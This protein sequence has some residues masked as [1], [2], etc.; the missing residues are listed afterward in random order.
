MTTRTK[1]PR[2]YHLP[3][4]PGAT[5]DDKRLGDTSLFEGREVVVTE[6]LDGECTTLY[7]DGL[8]ARSVDGARHAWQGP[9]RALH[10]GIAHL[11]P[12][13]WR[14]CGENVY[15]KHS[16]PY[17]QLPGPFFVFG[18]YDRETCL[19]W[20]DTEAMAAGLGL[21]VAPVL[22]RGRWDALAAE[23][24]FSGDG[25]YG[26]QEGFVVRV[27]DAFPSQDHPL[28]KWVRAGH[29][30]TGEHWRNRWTP[31]HFA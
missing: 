14:V 11:I 1:Y 3:T 24:C 26:P 4:S 17:E 5:S 18:I 12:S 31:N 15:A 8:H 28:A 21:P 20:D 19:S 2:T 16:I 23:D 29:V 9:V 30:Q 13:G 27:A 25:R 10:A 22:Y 7:S 6:K